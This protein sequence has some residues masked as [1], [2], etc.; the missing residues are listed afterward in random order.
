MRDGIGTE[1]DTD[2]EMRK[3]ASRSMFLE[4]ILPPSEDG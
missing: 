2:A 4:M 1:K 3:L